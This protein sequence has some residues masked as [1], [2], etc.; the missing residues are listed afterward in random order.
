MGTGASTVEER[1]GHAFA[2]WNAAFN[3]G[4]AN[5][6]AGFYSADAVLLP[7]THD[8]VN[9]PGD[10]GKFFAG[11]FANHVT[12]HSLEPFKIIDSGDTTIVA[13]KWSA[14]GQDEKGDKT[15][16]G[17]VATHVFQQQA[18]H[19]YTLKLHTFN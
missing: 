9:G 12:G 1:V 6:V 19:S 18:D 4:D 13:S 8:V 7:A 10:I 16:F 3:R 5:A 17:G 14:H 2:S 15:T 11:L